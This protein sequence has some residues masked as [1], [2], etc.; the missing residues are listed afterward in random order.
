VNIPSGRIRG[1]DEGTTIA[2]RG[3]PFAAPP[4]GD[5]RFRPPGPAPKWST[6]LDGSNNGA[7]CVQYDYEAKK[8]IGNED[9]LF[10]NV[11]APKS[12]EGP[13]PVVFWVHG[14]DNTSGGTDDYEGHALA[15]KANVVV[16]VANFR[17]GAFGWLAHPAFANENA[18]HSSGNYGL[19]DQIAALQWTKDN[20]A[21]FGGDPA[22]VLLT[23]QSAGANDVC[24]LMA[25]PLAKGLFSRVMMMSLTCRIPDAKL[26]ASTND[27]VTKKLGCTSGDVAGCLRGKKPEELALVPGASNETSDLDTDYAPVVD[28]RALTDAPEAILGR[29]EHQHAPVIIGSTKDEYAELLTLVDPKPPT[30]EQEYNAALS[31]LFGSEAAKVAAVYPVASYPSLAKALMAVYGDFEINCPTRAAARALAKSQSEPVFRYVFAQAAR[32]DVGAAQGLDVGHLFIDF[33]GPGT[34][35]QNALAGVLVDYVARFAKTG[36]VDGAA[37]AWPAFNPGEK[38]IVLDTALSD[39]S[40]YRKAECDV[41]DALAK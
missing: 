33:G 13:L 7:S 34:P 40:D 21:A 32:A 29:G 24:A 14:G 20:V 12:H 15:E 35:E 10:L 31:D 37:R 1:S 6:T 30:N 16:V 11:F 2:W 28:G 39:G 25:S 26:I 9:C 17:L 36:N 27:A 22:R 18:T 8:A 3:I 19:L 5:Q 41:L 4:T 38:H 23:G